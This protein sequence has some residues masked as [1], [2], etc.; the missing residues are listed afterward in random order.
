M[1]CASSTS[2]SAQG[3]GRRRRSSTGEQKDKIPTNKEEEKE[4]YERREN[5]QLKH[6]IVPEIFTRNFTEFYDVEK[7]VL[8]SGISGTVNLCTHKVTKLPFAVKSLTKKNIKREKYEQLKTEIRIM[9]SLDHPHILRLHECFE[10][11][12]YIYLVTELCKGGE[13]LDRLQRQR[14]HHYNERMAMELIFTILSAIKYCHAHKIVHRDLKLENFLAESEAHDSPIKLIDFGLSQHFEGAE[15]EKMHKAV[16]TPYYV[17]PEV[18]SNNYDAKC[19][20]WS[21]GVITYMLLSGIPPFN[22]SNNRELLDKVKIAKWKFD[23]RLFRNVSKD[24]KDF[25]TKCLTK[26]RA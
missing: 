17:A 21:I 7:K 12:N 25:I 8:G 4:T 11:D 3:N 15:G 19:D 14:S 26:V 20:V 18:L 5:Q 1:G 23:E 10:T 13:L 24:A 2:T 16:G 9:Q 6:N 22:G